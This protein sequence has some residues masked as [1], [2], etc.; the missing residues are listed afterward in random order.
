MKAFLKV[1][2][3]FMN[4][5]FWSDGTI[6]VTGREYMGIIESPCYRGKALSCLSCHSLHKSENDPRPL[7][8]VG[9]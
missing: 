1:N 5:T 6:R 2:P 4:N 9:Q 7:K 3:L 8:V